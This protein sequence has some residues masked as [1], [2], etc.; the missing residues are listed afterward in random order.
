MHQTNISFAGAGRVAEALCKEMFHAGFR[1]EVIVSETKVNGQ[2][3]ADSCNATWSSDLQF[4]GS[5]NIII[6]AVPDHRLKTVLETL[7]CETGTL[8]AHTAGSIGLDVFPEHI[9]QKGVFYPLQTFTKDSKVNFTGLPFFL[10]SSDDKS[11]EILKNLVESIHGKVHFVDTEQR[12]MLHLSAVFVCNFTN[13]MLTLGKEVV[14]KTGFPFDILYP[15]INET[16]SKAIVLGPENSQTGPAVR[17]DRNTIEKQLELLSFSPE[18]QRIYN[19]MTI[20]I[21]EYY[22]TKNKS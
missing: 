8:V 12:R 19:E 2:P 20:S 13:H 7:K 17:L 1:I 5:T 6:V 4:P 15:L 3:L 11:S 9:K 18:L 10:E 22:N 14:L 21:I 16:I